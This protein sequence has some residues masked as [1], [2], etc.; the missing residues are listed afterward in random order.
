MSDTSNERAVELLK[1]ANATILFLEGEL[2]RAKDALKENKEAAAREADN[3]VILEKVASESA[4]INFINTLE[5]YGF[6]DPADRESHMANLSKSANVIC[7]YAIACLKE[8]EPYNNEMG[9]GVEKEASTSESPTEDV[10]ALRLSFKSA[11]A[12]SLNSY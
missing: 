6:T 11:L 9:S 5:Y 4:L 10:N 1:M 12:S 7:N 2:E 8:S 3:K